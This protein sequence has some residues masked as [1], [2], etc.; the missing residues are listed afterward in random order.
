MANLGAYCHGINAPFL[1]HVL[2][3]PFMKIRHYG[4]QHPASSIPV[5]PNIA[6]VKIANGNAA[7]APV[8]VSLDPAQFPR[9]PEFGGT[10]I[11]RRFIPPMPIFSGDVYC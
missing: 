5:D 4:F 9:C 10:L 8:K 7:E 11:L 3:T 1:Q 2:P 6:S